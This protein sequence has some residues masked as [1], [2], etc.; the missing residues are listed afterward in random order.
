MLK[1]ASFFTRFGFV[2]DK[3]SASAFN[4]PSENKPQYIHV[5]GLSH[6]NTKTHKVP[7]WKLQSFSLILLCQA[8]CSCSCRTPRGSTRADSSADAETPPPPTA[9]G[10]SAARSGS[11]TTG[12]TTPCWPRPGGRACWVTRGSPTAC[13]ETSLT[14]A[15]TR[16]TGCS[17]SGTAAR[18][19]WT[20]ALPDRRKT[21]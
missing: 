12:P 20:P 1:C 13:S 4:F 5:T 16:T 7:F 17:T 10:R 14:S 6:H 8:P 21:K 2:H 9:R 3:F 11:V 18:R 19:K 15:P